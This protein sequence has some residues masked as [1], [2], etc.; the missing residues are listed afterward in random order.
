MTEPESGRPGYRRASLIAALVVVAVAILAL[1]VVGVTS[2]VRTDPAPTATASTP[3]AAP[4]SPTGSAGCPTD[5]ATVL[6]AAPV[7]T[8]QALGQMTL[9][10]GGSAFGP[11]RVTAIT[12][13]GYAR[14]P[15]GALVAAVQ[16]FARSTT[17]APVDVAV[18]TV[19]QQFVANGDRDLLLTSA[20]TSP[21]ASLSPERIARVAAYQIGTFSPDAVSLSVAYRADAMPGQYVVMR[22]VLQWVD[23]DWRMV[24]PIAGSWSGAGQTLAQLPGFTAWGP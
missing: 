12:A 8:W 22:L 3:P 10:T 5:T 7:V 2:L 16:I 15:G 17:S 19:Q 6:A 11:C 14:T 1:A 21:R 23:G 20:R 24:P 18:A 4:T 9:P 13:A